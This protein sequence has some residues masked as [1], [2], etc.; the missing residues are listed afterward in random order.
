MGFLTLFGL[1]GALIA[2]ALYLPMPPPSTVDTFSYGS[3]PSGFVWR[4]VLPLLGR[5]RNLLRSSEP[6]FAQ[7]HTQ[8]MN[9]QVPFLLAP[10]VERHVPDLLFVHGRLTA[11]E[12]GKRTSSD[13]LVL[14]RMLRRLT[15]AG[16]FSEIGDEDDL[17]LHAFENTPASEVLR[18]GR[19]PSARYGLLHAVHDIAPAYHRFSAVLDD[20]KASPFQ[21]A[22]QLE[23]QDIWQEYFNTKYPE[24]SVNFNKF[25]ESTLALGPAVEADFDWTQCDCVVDYGGG[26]GHFLRSILSHHPSIQ[27][28]VIFDLQPVISEAEE[29]WK[30]VNITLRNKV[31]FIAGSFFDNT[32]STPLCEGK[33]TC[34][35]MRQILHDWSDADSLRILNALAPRLRPQEDK[36]ILVEMLPDNRVSPDMGIEAPVDIVMLTFGGMER[37]P[38][39]MNALLEQAGFSPLSVTRVRGFP[40]VGVTTRK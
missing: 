34:Y 7:V 24:R 3:V 31:R 5:I 29:A 40:K 8:L 17:L 18:A 32:R 19:D 38:G 33:P 28:G 36:L 6:G 23:T 25:M 11:R 1:I 26:K 30:S 13:P 39:Q 12:L 37:T 14:Y 4:H 27:R 15:T 9:L 10:L 35:V 16:F 21:I 20:P 22:H 2:L